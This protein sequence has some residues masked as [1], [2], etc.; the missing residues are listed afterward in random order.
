MFLKQLALVSLSTMIFSCKSR[1]FN[2]T[3]MSDI[4]T[5]GTEDSIS[6]MGGKTTGDRLGLKAGEILLTLDDGPAPASIDIA[7]Y[8]SDMGIPVTYYMIGQNVKENPNTAMQ[9]AK[10]PN[11]IIANHSWSHKR[12]FNSVACIACDGADHAISEVMDADKILEPLYQA[13]K[14]KFFFFRAPGG[15][16]FRAGNAGEEADLA[17]LNKVAAKYVGP[18]RWDVD[19]DVNPVGEGGCGVDQLGPQACADIY[20]RQIRSLKNHGIVILAHDIHENAR[21]MIKLVVNQASEE[22]F[23]FVAHDKYPDVVAA[24]GKIK[25]TTPPQTEF[26]NITFTPTNKGNGTYE[27]MVKIPTAARIEIWVDGKTDGPLLKSLGD[28]FKMTYKFNTLGKRFFTIK[29]FDA[30]EKLM[31]Q[32]MRGITLT[33]DVPAPTPTPA[34]TPT[35]S[36]PGTACILA[37]TSS[38]GANLREVPSGTI[39][40]LVALNEKVKKIS[41]EGAWTKVEYLGKTGF[42]FSALLTD[43]CEK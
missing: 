9:I 37:V 28:V 29:G 4:K 34:A 15:N 36:A 11:T 1:D 22:G 40:Q 14:T 16:F 23:K 43:L 8:L 31:A 24:V 7:K 30:K 13:N 26:G 12:A 6:D 17:Q 25:P 35:P 42:L 3:D 39:L 33:N 2:K 18:V 19:G 5:F 21:R 20:M 10:L 38:D 27:F 32:S 41:V